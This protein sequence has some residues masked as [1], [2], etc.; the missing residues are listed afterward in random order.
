MKST[1]PCSLIR[2]TYRES[3]ASL[4][5]L[6]QLIIKDKMENQTKSNINLNKKKEKEKKKR[7]KQSFPQSNSIYLKKKKNNLLSFIFTFRHIIILKS[8]L[9]NREL[10]L[11]GAEFLLQKHLKIKMLKNISNFF[12]RNI[13]WIKC[14]KQHQLSIN[15]ISKI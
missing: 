3:I 9:V 12:Y 7:E 13:I 1:I 8:K 10:A 11:G 2:I 5:P 14:L 15:L 4:N 6:L